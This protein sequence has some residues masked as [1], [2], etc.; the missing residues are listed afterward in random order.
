M[1]KKW[2]QWWIFFL[3]SKITVD[4]DCTHEI[5]R[6]LLLGRKAMTN[7]DNIL[8]S[9]D[10]ILLTNIHRAKTMVFPAAMYKC[11]SWTIKK[12]EHQRID[13]FEL[14]CWRRLLRVPWTARRSKP[15]ILKEISPEYS[16]EGLMLKLKLQYSGHLMGRANSLEKILMLGKIKGRRIR[17]WRR[18]WQPTSVLLPGK[19]HGWRSLVG[20]SPWGR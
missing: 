15:A 18:Q 6:H 4:S 20:C 17:K 8:K 14:W 3:G 12:A 7:L 1:G 13:A 5:K 9:R 19:S 11:E 10:I 16:L 2:T